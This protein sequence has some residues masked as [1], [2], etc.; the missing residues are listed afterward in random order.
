[1][2]EKNSENQTGLKRRIICPP[3]SIDKMTFVKSR[4]IRVGKRPPT[5]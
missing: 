4:K 1:M 3:T 2:H 5:E